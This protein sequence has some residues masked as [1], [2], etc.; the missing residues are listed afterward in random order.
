MFKSKTGNSDIGFG[1]FEI[2]QVIGRGGY[3]KVY[4]ARL[5]GQQKLYAIKAIAKNVLIED[6]AIES[7]VL[8]KNIMMECNHPFLIHMDYLF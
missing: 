4:L 2:V 8:E 1:D 5:K 6:E 3:G 7:T